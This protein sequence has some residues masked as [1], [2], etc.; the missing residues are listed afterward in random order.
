MVITQGK[1]AGV[2]KVKALESEDRTGYPCIRHS[3]SVSLRFLDYK[4]GI[5][6]RW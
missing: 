4:M 6:G 1:E 5:H 3:T 2:L